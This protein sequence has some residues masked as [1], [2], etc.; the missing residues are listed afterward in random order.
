LE[1]NWPATLPLRFLR[2]SYTPRF[3]RK[4]P[5][6]TGLHEEA[7]GRLL[8]ALGHVV[9]AH[10]ESGTYMFNFSE[11]LGTASAATLADT[12]HPGN[13]PGVAPVAE[14]VAFGIASDMGYDVLREFWPEI[15]RKLKLPFRG[16][17]DN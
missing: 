15:A 9:L 8:H 10:E 7:R 2:I 17:Q 4:I 13:R 16:Q 5:G 3:F 12:Y 14:N 1:L 6:T 11:W